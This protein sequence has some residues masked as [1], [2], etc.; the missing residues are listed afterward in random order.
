MSQ[1]K[2]GLSTLHSL[3]EPFK[4]M[5][6]YLTKTKTK[7]VEIIDGGI[8]TLNKRRVLTL[9]TIGESYD[10][11]YSVH[12]PFED[13]NIASLS[14]PLL[15]AMVK[16]LEKSIAYSNSLNAYMWIFHPGLRTGVS[17]FYP[18]VDW[19]QNLKTTELLFR[20]ADDYGV[21]IAV[22]NVPEPYPF[23]MKSVADFLKFYNEVKEQI[24]LVLDIGHAHINGQTELF[25]KT[26]ADKIVHIHAHDN[27]G[28][29]DQ[30]LG[31]GYGTVD[32]VNVANI[33]KR[34]FYDKVVIVESF[35][36][37]EESMQKLKES[38]A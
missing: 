29:N 4:K 25:L 8:H 7:Y 15:K 31:I 34:I 21:K 30:H 19:L 17:W 33:L 12:A 32:W 38:L 23:L 24:D 20:I 3:G 2:I 18:N 36:R 22:E 5:T 10:L 16:R 14:K 11:R 37:T 13:I 26:F 9:K 1:P 6:E 27:D 28:K 35:Y